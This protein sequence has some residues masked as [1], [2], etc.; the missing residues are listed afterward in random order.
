MDLI[1]GQRTFCIGVSGAAVLDDTITQDIAF[2]D[3]AGNNIKCSYFKLQV[4]GTNGAAKVLGVVA[5]VSGISHVGDAVTDSLSAIK[6]TVST[7]G[8]CGIGTVA[9]YFQKGEDVWHGSNGQVATGVKLVITNFGAQANYNIMLTYGN[10]FPLNTLRTTN[11][12]IYDAG[13]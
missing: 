1:T 7:S 8:I 4:G 6:A 13:V 12:L 9:A 5:E 11:N 2:V 3:S 10:L